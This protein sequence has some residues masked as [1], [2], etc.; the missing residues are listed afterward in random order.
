MK[1]KLHLITGILATLTI[2]SFFISTITVELFGSHE[3]VATV[4]SFIVIPG[5]F[6]LVPAIAASVGTGFALSKTRKGRLVNAKQKRM[7]FIGASGVIVLI[8]CAIF[9]DRWALAGAF[10]TTFYIVQGIELLAG[11]TNLTLMSMNIRDG[12]RTSGRFY[13][14]SQQNR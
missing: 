12:L 3:A 11:A 7:P 10:N 5:L 6:I 2:A 4:K 14:S 13:A 9:L 8:P 1:Q